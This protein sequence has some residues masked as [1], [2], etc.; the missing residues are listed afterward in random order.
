MTHTAHEPP[1]VLQ[2]MHHVGM[3][4][5]PFG[6]QS[7]GRRVW[8]STYMAYSVLGGA[9]QDFERVTSARAVEE[10]ARAHRTHGANVAMSWVA[11]QG[12]ALVVISASAAHMRDDLRILGEP[13]WGRLQQAEMATLSALR[14][15]AGRPSHWGDCEDEQ[16][17]IPE[18]PS[19]ELRE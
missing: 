18:R 16:I 7:F 11:Q 12:V 1:A 14:A 17:D 10:I 19:P 3:G 9:E 2:Y 4:H 8:G 6:Y 13:P 15:P 5:D